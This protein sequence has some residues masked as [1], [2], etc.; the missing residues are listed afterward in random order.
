MKFMIPFLI[1][2]IPVVS[3]AQSQSGASQGAAQR[4]YT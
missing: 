1:A 2:M 4:G 3:V